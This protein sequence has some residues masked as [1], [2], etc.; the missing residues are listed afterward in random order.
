MS[1]DWSLLDQ[2]GKREYKFVQRDSYREILDRYPEKYHHGVCLGTAMNWIQEK[3]STSNGLLRLNGPLMSPVQRQFSRPL[4]PITRIKEGISP[5]RNSPFATFLDKGKSGARNEGAM[6][7]GASSQQIYLDF[8]VSTLEQRLRLVTSNYD[9]QSKVKRGPGN[10]PERIHDATIANAAIELPKE[11]A[12]LIELEQ[13]KGAGHAIAFY[14]S[15]GGTLYFFDPNAGVYSI[16]KPQEQAQPQVDTFERMRATSNQ[17]AANTSASGNS[18]NS[19]ADPDTNAQRFIKRWLAVY[20]I[21]DG[22]QWETLKNNWCRT[23]NRALPG[24]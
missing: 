1:R 13:R 21:A 17:N 8:G 2:Y 14:K 4:N 6:L 19:P 16:P 15:H 10:I 22:I 11:C 5:A 7:Q 9:P 3:L 23:Y 24:N 20:A 12:M 18:T